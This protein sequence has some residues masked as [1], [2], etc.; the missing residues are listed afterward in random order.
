[1]MDSAERRTV[2]TLKS[3]FKHIATTLDATCI[4][5]RPQPHLSTSLSSSQPEPALHT[6]LTRILTDHHRIRGSALRCLMTALDIDRLAIDKAYRHIALLH[7]A[8]AHREAAQAERAVR[9]Y[10]PLLEVLHVA[11]EK[12]GVEEWDRWTRR[13]DNAER[14]EALGQYVPF[15]FAAASS[16]GAQQLPLP[17]AHLLPTLAERQAYDEPPPSSPPRSPPRTFHPALSAQPPRSQRQSDDEEETAADG[18]QSKDNDTLLKRAIEA[19][20]RARAKQAA[21]KAEKER[22]QRLEAKKLQAIRAAEEKEK[23]ETE[24]E[25]EEEQERRE[26]E[27]E[28]KEVDAID[29]GPKVGEGKNGA[30]TANKRQP[31]TVD[32]EADAEVQQLSSMHNDDA[33]D[34]ARTG[35]SSPADDALATRPQLLAGVSQSPTD[36]SPVNGTA[37]GIGLASP[38]SKFT[39]DLI[40]GSSPTYAASNGEPSTFPLSL[41]NPPL[42]SHSFARTNSFQSAEKSHLPSHVPQPATRPARS[43]KKAPRYG[44]DD[45]YTPNAPRTPKPHRSSPSQPA[46][47]PARPASPAPPAESEEDK[48]WEVEDVL[49]YRFRAYPPFHELAGRSYRSFLMLWKEY[50][51]AT[52]VMEE[53]LVSV[54]KRRLERLEEWDDWRSRPG[55]AAVEVE[56]EQPWLAPEEEAAD[57]GGSQGR[58]KKSKKRKK[59]PPPRLSPSKRMPH[60]QLATKSWTPTLQGADAADSE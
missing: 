32:D 11:M 54:D 7:G 47:K 34:D 2:E 6:S 27:G 22:A 5:M 3:S 33:A 29:H 17:I 12:N 46:A 26:D 14:D 4:T 1:M 15:P 43:R 56:E 9:G 49:C 42:S 50:P 35:D 20:N 39:S 13:Q 37:N 31:R 30:L 18:V 59:T 40:N 58:K 48:L 24:E 53:E 23:H 8:G 21:A 25:A 38:F 10:P 57:G 44:E 55:N 51:R 16:S 28:Q 52:W 41:T 19:D 45:L 36:V 60:R